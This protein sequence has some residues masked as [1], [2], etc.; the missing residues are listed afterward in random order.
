MIIKFHMDIPEDDREDF[1]AEC[2]KLRI[3]Q[4]RDICENYDLKEPGV[5]ITHSGIEFAP[6]QLRYAS[7]L[8]GL[9]I[10]LNWWDM[11]WNDGTEHRELWDHLSEQHADD[12][13]ASLHDEWKD[14][15]L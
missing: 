3:A 13:A 5:N 12:I 10:D 2:R 9:I 4:L 14:R 6:E 11:K 7:D 15:H 1:E 8:S